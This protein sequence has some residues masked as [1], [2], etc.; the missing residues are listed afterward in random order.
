AA[1]IGRPPAR[2]AAA[3]GLAPDLRFNPVLLKPGS[4]L[5][6]QVV[7][8]GEAI[9]TVTAGNYRALRP[10]LAETAHATLAEL[11]T[12]YDVVICEGAGSPA[13]SHPRRG[14]CV[15]MWA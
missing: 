3:C 4:D 14:R 12:E 5:S 13:E 15:H 1:E 7:L 8:L 6:S 10:R 2:Q 11:R 9:D